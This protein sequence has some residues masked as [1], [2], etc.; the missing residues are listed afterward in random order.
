[1]E[2]TQIQI[3][4]KNYVKANKNY[5]RNKFKAWREK[6]IDYWNEYQRNYRYNK[7]GNKK[8]KFTESQTISNWKRHKMVLLDGENWHDIYEMFKNTTHC[9]GCDRSFYSIRKNLDHCHKTGYI[10][11]VLCSHCNHYTVDVFKDMF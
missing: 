4:R 2:L 7:N 9:Q 11:G 6:N 3:Y 10:R 8:P 1:M 5:Y